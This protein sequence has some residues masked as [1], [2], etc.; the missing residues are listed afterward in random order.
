MPS[1]I[2]QSNAYAEH[3]TVLGRANSWGLH[4]AIGAW[5]RA[6]R[7]VNTWSMSSAP[8]F[9]T[10]RNSSLYTVSVTLVELC[11]TRCEISSVLTPW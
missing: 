10:G 11:P 1:V 8:V 7:G 5:S 6:A 3:A 2:R 4:H 9:I